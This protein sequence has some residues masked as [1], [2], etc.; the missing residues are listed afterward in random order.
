M[1]AKLA[2]QVSFTRMLHTI[3]KKSTFIQHLRTTIVGLVSRRARRRY[4]KKSIKLFRYL[5]Q[6][7]ALKTSHFSM[8]KNA[9]LVKNPLHIL[10]STQS[11]VLAAQPERF[12]AVTCIF[13]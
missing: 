5:I 7:L 2:Q 6:W 10:A 1:A 13:V 11:N 12:S 9:F 8:E 3:A 4:N